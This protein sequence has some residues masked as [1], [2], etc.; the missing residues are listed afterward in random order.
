MHAAALTLNL[1]LRSHISRRWITAAARTHHCN[2]DVLA[3]LEHQTYHQTMRLWQ[4]TDLISHFAQG[5]VAC[6]LQTCG[7]LRRSFENAS[8]WPPLFVHAHGTAILNNHGPSELVAERMF[9]ALQVRTR[10]II[11]RK[12]IV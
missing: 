11:I 3:L 6:S 5:P 9:H 2:G 1:L 8:L 7:A 12:T 10:T 4:R